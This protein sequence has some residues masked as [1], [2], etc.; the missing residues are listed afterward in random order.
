MPHQAACYVSQMICGIIYSNIYLYFQ[1]AMTFLSEILKLGLH[2]Q[3]IFTALPLVLLVF[4]LFLSFCLLVVLLVVGNTKGFFCFE[5]AWLG[6]KLI[7]ELSEQVQTR[8]AT[9]NLE[10]ERLP[11]PEDGDWSLG[12]WLIAQPSIC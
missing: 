7:F 10:L 3:K 12:D 2:L 11:R 4:L 6:R 1:E 5:A 9:G 8:H